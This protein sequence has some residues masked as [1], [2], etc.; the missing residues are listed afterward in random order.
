LESHVV[1]KRL[2]E[3]AYIE[4]QLACNKNDAPQNLRQHCKHIMLQLGLS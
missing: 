1:I 2:P 3:P 4:Q